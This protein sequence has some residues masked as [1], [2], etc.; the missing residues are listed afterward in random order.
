MKIM[1]VSFSIDVKNVEHVKAL[2]EFMAVLGE[3]ATPVIAPVKDPVISIARTH[4]AV[5]PEPS[6]TA[7]PKGKK[8]TKA[9]A[10]EPETVEAPEQSEENEAQMP[11]ESPEGKTQSAIDL[12]LLRTEVST[13][14]KRGTEMREQIKAKLKDFGAESVSTLDEAHYDEFFA[15]LKTL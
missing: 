3:H 10:P 15:Y 13:L 12:P 8:A 2:T 4:E 7:V 5:S 1:N 6:T 11:G 14:A 9:E